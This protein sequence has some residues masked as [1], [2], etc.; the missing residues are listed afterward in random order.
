MD[1][2]H[3]ITP[4]VLDSAGWHCSVLRGAGAAH[5]GGGLSFILGDSDAALLT[6]TAEEVLRLTRNTVSFPA[7]ACQ[8]HC[9]RLQ[10]HCHFSVAIRELRQECHFDS[11][12]RH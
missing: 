7:G 1:I 6:E 4:S 3:K 9:G 10:S 5:A 11:H 12:D 8:G 2:L